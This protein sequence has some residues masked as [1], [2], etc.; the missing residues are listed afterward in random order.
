MPQVGQSVKYLSYICPDYESPMIPAVQSAPP[1]A[2]PYARRAVR[3]VGQA[4]K[5][6]PGCPGALRNLSDCCGGGLE[7]GYAQLGGQHLAEGDGHAATVDIPQQHLARPA[8]QHGKDA[9][10]REAFR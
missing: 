3:R 6:A 8:A 2:L 9:I 5:N 7:A 4:T 1:A 10:A